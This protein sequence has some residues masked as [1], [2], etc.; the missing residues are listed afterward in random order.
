M[1]NTTLKNTRERKNSCNSIDES[2]TS[3]TRVTMVINQ[4]KINFYLRS[5]SL[6]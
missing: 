1:T 3:I 5:K 6:N 4:R 2:Y